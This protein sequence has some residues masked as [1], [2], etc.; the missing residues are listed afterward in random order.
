MPKHRIKITVDGKGRAVE[1]MN[2]FQD[3]V[4]HKKKKYVFDFNV[5]SF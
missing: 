4:I 5:Y 2:L 1:D 3:F